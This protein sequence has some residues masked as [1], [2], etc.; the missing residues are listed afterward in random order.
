MYGE[1]NILIHGYM[2]GCMN[3]CIDIDTWMHGEMNEQRDI[4]IHGY[5]EG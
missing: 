5:M 4:L 1:R 3:G 2:K